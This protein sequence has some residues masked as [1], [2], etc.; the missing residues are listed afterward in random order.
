[1]A[2]ETKL[3]IFC[4]LALGVAL[5]YGVLKVTSAWHEHHVSRHD[6]IAESKRLRYAYLKAIADR[7]REML[8]MQEAEGEG[9]VIIDDDEPQLAQAA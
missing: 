3:M 2:I 6:L 8:A 1:M 4:L 5:V 7:D 9:S